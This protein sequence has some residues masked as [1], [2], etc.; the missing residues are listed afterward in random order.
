VECRR[1][2]PSASHEANQPERQGTESKIM[3]DT[4]KKEIA[5]DGC[6]GADRMASGGKNAS[7]Q[8]CETGKDVCPTKDKRVMTG[9]QECLPHQDKNDCPTAD[10][11][12]C[13]NGQ[14]NMSA[15]GEKDAKGLG[16]FGM[17]VGLD[18]P[19]REMYVSTTRAVAGVSVASFCGL[20]IGVVA[21]SRNAHQPGPQ[22]AQ[23]ADTAKYPSIVA[24]SERDPAVVRPSVSAKATPKPAQVVVTTPSKPAPLVTSTPAKT[25]VVAAPTTAPTV[26]APVTTTASPEDGRIIGQTYFVFG[27]FPKLSEAKAVAERLKQN[28][29]TCT[30]ERSLPGWTRK[31][32]YSVV[33]VKG[34][35][36]SK[37]VTYQQEMK[38]LQAKELDP[39]GYKWRTVKGA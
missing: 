14:E 16:R 9:R 5:G 26:S 12:V 29:V 17:R 31:G 38:S 8:P 20:L 22:G 37:D 27:S 2:D 7:T 32:W 25:P 10:K 33:S 28:G 35:D 21:L 19:N 6:G 1:G 3:S 36:S 24:P 39:R 23:A 4:N 11:D 18:H 15:T 30:V 34:F 13:S